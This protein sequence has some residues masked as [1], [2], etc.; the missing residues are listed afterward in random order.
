MN[1]FLTVPTH[2]RWRRRAERL[3]ELSISGSGG[4]DGGFIRGVGVCDAA[5]NTVGVVSQLCEVH[6]SSMTGSKTK[7][8]KLQEQENC[9]ETR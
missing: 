6:E 3:L 7:G 1:C 8:K 5:L 2:W 4:G 9:K